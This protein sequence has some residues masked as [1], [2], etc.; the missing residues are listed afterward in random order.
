MTDVRTAR[1][2]WPFVIVVL[3]CFI[4]QSLSPTALSLKLLSPD[5]I[6]SVLQE[7]L[8]KYEFWPSLHASDHTCS[9]AC[10]KIKMCNFSWTPQPSPAGHI[11]SPSEKCAE[12]EKDS[13]L[14]FSDKHTHTRTS[15]SP[16]ICLSVSIALKRAGREEDLCGLRELNKWPD[17]FKK[18]DF[19]VGCG[20]QLQWSDWNLSLSFCLSLPVLGG[21]MGTDLSTG[22][23][24]SAGKDGI[25]T[26]YSM[27]PLHH[28][29]TQPIT[30]QILFQL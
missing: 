17:S 11:A 4:R 19:V 9:P 7:R 24:T 20:C 5:A 22:A 25:P 14:F 1:S 15:L 21:L 3:S 18:E 8:A 30:A 12:V 27:F 13:V 16:Y 26:Y 10:L 23:G 2:H 6:S 28:I 29:F